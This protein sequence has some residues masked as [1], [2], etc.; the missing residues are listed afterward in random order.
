MEYTTRD[1]YVRQGALRD[2][3]IKIKACSLIVPLSLVVDLLSCLDTTLKQ[4]LM[5]K[6][7]LDRPILFQKKG[8]IMTIGIRVRLAV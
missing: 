5:L 7:V 4:G 2:E 8:A 3:G 1:S 6:P